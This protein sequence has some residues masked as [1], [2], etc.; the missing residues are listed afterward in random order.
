[1]PME[2]LTGVNP[3]SFTIR[4]P[5]PFDTWQESWADDRARCADGYGSLSFLFFSEDPFEIERARTICRRCPRRAACFDV[6]LERQEGYGVWGGELFVG[7]VPMAVRPT[8][9]RPPKVPRVPPVIDEVPV[10][11]HLLE[12]DRVA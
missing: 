3:T 12:R 2:R 7:G 9:G 11:P 8:R 10:A 6:A 5:S 1:M 4:R